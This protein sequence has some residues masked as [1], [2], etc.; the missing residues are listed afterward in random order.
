VTGGILLSVV[1]AGALPER[2]DVR[3]VFFYVEVTTARLNTLT[4]LFDGGK[5]SL[6]VGSV[7][8]LK[9]ASVAHEMLGGAPH[10]RGKIV[11]QLSVSRDATDPQRASDLSQNTD[12]ADLL[13]VRG[14]HS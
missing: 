7:L 5:L 9:E 3:R 11:L 6:R 4:E 12:E 2:S 13:A 1:S 8:P 14:L 10:K